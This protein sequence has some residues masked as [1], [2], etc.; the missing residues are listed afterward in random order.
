MGFV[1]VT[2]L[3]WKDIDTPQDL[4]KARNLYWKILRRELIRPGD[5]LISRYLN[6]LI[7]SNLSI[8]L[9]RRRTYIN[10][11]IISLISFLTSLAGAFL[12]ALH[13]LI[14]GGILIQA[15]SIID[16]MDGEM[17]RLFK[18]VSRFGA[19]FDSFL[20]RVADLSII[21]GIIFALWPLDISL[22]IIAALASANMILVSY[23][24]HLLRESGIDPS[25]I[26][27]IPVTR[28]V[29]LFAI[30]VAALFNQLKAAL[31]FLAFTPFAYYAAGVI[32]ARRSLQQGLPRLP[33]KRTPWPATPRKV[34]PVK[35]VISS[36]I[37]GFLK[38]FIALLVLKLL[39][40]IFAELPLISLGGE[41]LLVSHTLL[42]LEMVL[43]LYFGYSIISSMRK[44][45]DLIAVR[46]VS[47]VGA[48]KDT[49]K[50]IFLDF[51]YAVLG[52]IAWA[53]ATKLKGIPVIGGS[54][55]KIA[56]AAAAIFF[57]ITL[58]RLGRRI[59]KAFAGIYDRLV[60]GLAKKLSHEPE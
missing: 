20:D 27:R 52:L 14:L 7:S 54:A 17:A 6:R 46:L 29:R 21:A 43:V 34:T 33:L 12:L 9:Y 35:E 31:Y 58:Y 28:D 57:F 5:G 47:R 50:K 44:L 24:T 41:T 2:G 48:T 19:V 25:S 37:G 30:F 39:T 56:M 18:R 22:T 23:V 11:N 55:S 15:S 60:E 26:R 51:L 1:D 16:G 36:I 38:L 3:L 49:L 59:Y 45:S 40:P 10:P 53:Y 4:E 8:T 42:I 13:S 32:L